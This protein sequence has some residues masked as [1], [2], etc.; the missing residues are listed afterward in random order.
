[1]STKLAVCFV[2]ALTYV[3]RKGSK[4]QVQEKH[5]FTQSPSH[6]WT[7]FKRIWYIPSS[8]VIVREHN[9]VFLFRHVSTRTGTTTVLSTSLGKTFFCLAFYFRWKLFALI[10]HILA[11]IIFLFCF[12]VLFSSIYTKIKFTAKSWSDLCNFYSKVSFWK[13]CLRKYVYFSLLNLNY[14]CFTTIL[15]KNEQEELVENMALNY[16]PYRFLHDVA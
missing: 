10:G 2:R 16:L 5:L 9:V 11:E 7:V 3:P 1:M 13:F 14:W 15:R 4:G 6:I 8:Y 12:C